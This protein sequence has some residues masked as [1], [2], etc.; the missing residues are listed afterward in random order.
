MIEPKGKDPYNISVKFIKHRDIR[1][2]VYEEL[3]N[4]TCNLSIIGTVDN[5]QEK[6][7]VHMENDTIK[8]NDKIDNL[9]I[10]LNIEQLVDNWNMEGLEVTF[11]SLSRDEITNFARNI[12]INNHPL[13]FIIDEEIME[14]D[15]FNIEIKNIPLIPINE[16]EAR[17]WFVELISIELERIVG[18]YDEEFVWDTA[19]KI[20]EKI[21]WNS[22]FPDLVNSLEIEE[23][24]E[25]TRLADL[26]CPSKEV[27]A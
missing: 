9:P 17:K 10:S 25:R 22:Y 26:L 1:V 2:P 4:T 11:K 20:Y 18:Y 13:H 7:T 6:V 19:D 24:K 3:P 16:N 23:F 15:G 5:E 14:E 12:R 8:L 21:P 27:E